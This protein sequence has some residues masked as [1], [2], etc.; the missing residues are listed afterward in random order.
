MGNPT[1]TFESWNQLFK[2]RDFV[3]LENTIIN[4]EQKLNFICNKGHKTTIVG[5]VF[6]KGGGCKECAYERSKKRT[7]LSQEYVSDFFK[8]NGC[9]LLSKYENNHTPVKF[10]CVC[11]KKS[12]IQFNNFYMGK[13]C[14]WCKS[15]RF[16]GDKNPSWRYD[17]ENKKNEE[18][19]IKKV[20]QVLYSCFKRK[21]L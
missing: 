7:T 1:R 4:R 13:R 11:G 21:K 6:L 14:R 9:V 8:S 3:L 18:K 20:R 19:F 15:N 10:I 12:F 16:K 2:D 5:Q 17:R